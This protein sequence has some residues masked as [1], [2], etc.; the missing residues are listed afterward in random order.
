MS[1]TADDTAKARKS[2]AEYPGY[3]PAEGAAVLAKIEHG[4]ALA[5]GAFVVVNVQL[6]GAGMLFCAASRAVTET[7][8]VADCANGPPGVNVVWVRNIPTR[9]Q[10][11][12]SW[13]RC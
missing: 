3:V 5:G 13:P 11:S 10:V 6:S 4:Q 7:V 2:C 8:Y 12:S 9:C 1:A